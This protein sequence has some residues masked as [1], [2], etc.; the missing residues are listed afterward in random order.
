MLGTD[1][2]TQIALVVH[3]IDAT[4]E[5]YASLLGVDKPEA[6]MTDAYEHSGAEYRG[7]PTRARAKLAFFKVGP[8]LTLELIE[9]DHE[10]STWR[11]HL[12]QHGEGVHHIA[13]RVEDMDE[14]VSRLDA[15][16]MPLVQSGRFPGGRYAY[17]DSRG[18]LKT[19]LELLARA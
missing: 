2:V 12:D 15:A 9:P 11:E 19:T 10:P 6:I 13:F 8:Q 5:A 17:M 14:T 7:Q 4:S 18:A 1:V 3:D 16:G